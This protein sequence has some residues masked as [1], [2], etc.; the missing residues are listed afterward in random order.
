[1]I[2]PRRA[3]LRKLDAFRRNLP[4][5]SASALAAV[6]EAVDKEGIPDIHNRNAL[7]EARDEINDI[8]TPF[9]AIH[10]EVMMHG[11]RTAQKKI[12]LAHP[13]ALMWSALTSSQSFND[14]FDSRV[15]DNPPSPEK[16]WRLIL[17]ND[18]VTPGNPLGT[19]NKRKL[20]AVYFSF[21]EFGANALS[22]EEAWFTIMVER[23]AIIRDIHAGMYQA[24]KVIVLMFFDD[25]GFDCQVGGVNLPLGGNQVRWWC[26]LGLIVQDGGAHKTTWHFRGEG[27]TKMCLLC[28]NVFADSS[29][30]CDQDGVT[31]LRCNVIKTNELVPATDY[32]IRNAYRVLEANSG[33]QTQAEFTRLQQA[34]G[35]TYHPHALLADPRMDRIISPTQAYV[36]DW[37]HGLF[38]DGVFNTVVYLLFEDFYD[39]GRK[40]IYDLFKTYLG[41]WHWPGR[42]SS[43]VNVSDVFKADRAKKHREAMHIKCQASELMTVAPVLALFVQR[44]L[45]PSGICAEACWAFLALCDVVDLVTSTTKVRVDPQ[46]LRVAVEKFLALYTEHW[47][48]EWLGPK[49]H[50]LLHYPQILQIFGML[51]NCFVHERYHRICKRYANDLKNYNQAVSGI[52]REVTADKMASLANQDVFNFT[53]CLVNQKPANSKV[54][55]LVRMMLGDCHGLPITTSWDTRYSLATCRRK[56]I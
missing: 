13:L 48:V 16:P 9:G 3:K 19:D 40:N 8:H 11:V 23:S 49:F 20:Q 45:L 37:M 31:M 2:E 33:T 39:A 46:S 56:D 1:M 51:F 27:G 4:H 6:L 7:R 44:V 28:Q 55:A 50:W 36:H 21:L 24:L 53:I 18:E 15:K 17:Y 29:N 22:K 32:Q 34:L 38:V 26:K 30:I 43:M 41:K 54:E 52:L 47:G 25:K 12:R 35:L 5:M 14:F 10:R 42:I